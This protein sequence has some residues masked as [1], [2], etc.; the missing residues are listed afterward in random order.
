MESYATFLAALVTLLV[1]LAAGKLWERYKLREGRW[2]DRRKARESPHYILG[3]NF[4]VANQIDRA[5]DELS[6]AARLQPDALEIEMI[7]GNLYREKGQVG[8]A[9]TIHQTL[10][11][12]P[13]LA[14]LEHAYILLCLGLDY[15]RGGFV[16][17]AL[18]AFNEVLRLDSQNPYAMM[19]LEK[20]LAGAAA[21]MARKGY[22]HTSIR[23]VGRET[24]FSVAGMYYYFRGKEELLYK[25]QDQTFG[26][27]LREQEGLAAQEVEP[28]EKLRILVCNHLS[29][30]TTHAHE[31]KVCTFELD[32]LQGDYYRKIERLR[33]RYFKLVA[34]LIEELMRQTTNRD[35]SID[36]VRHHA[37]FL[38][39]MLNWTLMWFDPRRDRPIEALGNQMVD[40]VLHGLPAGAPRR[41]RPVRLQE[42]QS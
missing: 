42:D 29:F 8:R 9:I 10:L 12:R 17:R 1:G 31:L 35:P 26:T 3:L 25:I 15:K 18:E 11:Q 34:G 16:D 24:G 30:L 7:L 14:K 32:S 27:L 28:A 2:I 22:D 21:L 23:D 37:L 13:K 6:R 33:K 36:E 4:L 5:I 20:L 41:G 38:F 39:G 19:N 40:L